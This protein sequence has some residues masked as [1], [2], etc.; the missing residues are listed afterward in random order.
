MVLADVAF[1]IC[2]LLGLA[3]GTK[4][5]R[6]AY[7]TRQLPELVLGIATSSQV[8]AALGFWALPA[9]LPEGSIWAGAA[10]ALFIEALGSIALCIGCWVLFRRNEPWAQ[11]L[12]GALSLMVLG[13]TATRLAMSHPELSSASMPLGH[14]PQLPLAQTLTN[15]GVAA[16]YGWAAFEATRYGLL[17]RRRLRLGLDHP[18]VV[19]QFLL[20]G[21]ASAS[22]V[23]INVLVVLVLNVTGRP[24]TEL[25]WA[26]GTIALIAFVGAVALWAA[27][28]PSRLQRSWAERSREALG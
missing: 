16:A 28:F 4:L 6:L 17:M 27:F 11:W 1:G 8:A 5:L 13:L 22:I 24:E 23:V 12:A 18:I 25:P 21:V 2:A 9:L 10:V 14:G 26:H 15:L 3:V 20:W 19:H 7:R